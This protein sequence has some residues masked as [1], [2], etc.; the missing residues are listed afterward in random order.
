MEMV[1]IRILVVDQEVVYE[2]DPIFIQVVSADV[3]NAALER[4]GGIGEMKMYGKILGRTIMGAEGGF[5][6]L[7]FRNPEAIE[8]YTEIKPGKDVG[9]VQTFQGFLN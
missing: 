6:F 7:A 5:P 3:V 9:S 4:R 1:F 8:H 2:G